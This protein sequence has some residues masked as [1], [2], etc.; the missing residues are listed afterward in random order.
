MAYTRAEIFNKCAKEFENKSAFYQSKVVNYRGVTSDTKELYNEIV[1]EFILNNLEE[2]VT[3]IKQIRRETIYKTES[4]TGDKIPDDKRMEEKIAVEMFNMSQKQGFVFD[5]IGKII[6]YQ[7]PLKNKS[8]DD[9]G[10]IDLLAYDGKILR[11]LELKKPDSTET[12]LRCVLEGFTYMQTIKDKE[13]FLKDFKLPVDTEIVACPFVFAYGEQWNEMNENRPRLKE[14]MKKL[15]SKPYFIDNE[16]RI[17]RKIMELNKILDYAIMKNETTQNPDIKSGYRINENTYNNYLENE[18]FEKF[19]DD[20][21]SNHKIAYKMYGEGSGNEL[22][23]RKGRNGVLYPPKMASFGSSSRMIYNLMKDVDVFLFEKQLPTTVGGTANLDGFMET[24]SKYLFVEAKCREPYSAKT[25]EYE[26]K[27]EKLYE[28]ITKSTKTN[29]E[30]EIISDKAKDKKMKVRF[31]VNNEVIK[32]FDI[33]QMICHL[34]GV[35]TAFLKGE[36][37]MKNIEFIYL[38]FN[39]KL[40]EI[41]EEKSKSR[42]HK[43]YTQT[44]EECNLVDFKNL[45]EVIIEFLKIEYKMGDNITTSLLVDN[46]KFRLSDQN[47][48][49]KN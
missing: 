2:F 9:I 19:V 27:Y 31:K 39:P 10:K 11:I 44:C 1:A 8:K 25:N 48:M 34:L 5:N 18:C 40:I 38:L 32:H 36:F 26:W 4:H 12:M 22:E 45:F 17:E 37:D 46:F 16:Y 20:M 43:I 29:L 35:A 49:R 28:Y 3:G 21:K 30:C 33:K 13:K 7:T 42:I 14:L 15:N 41:E 47:N 6:D 24:D 23:I